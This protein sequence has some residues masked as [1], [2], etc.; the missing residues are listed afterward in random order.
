MAEIEKTVQLLQPSMPSKDAQGKPA[1]PLESIQVL[2]KIAHN[3]SNTLSPVAPCLYN[4]LSTEIPL[5]GSDVDHRDAPERSWRKRPI[6]RKKSGELIRPAVRPPSARRWAS[7]MPGTPTFSKAVHFDSHLE[8]VRLFL[9]V[10]RPW[11]VSAGSSPVEAYDSDTEFL[12]G[13]EDSSN[14]RSPPYEWEL[15]A[16]KFPAKTPQRLLLSVRV[17]KVFLS[18]DNEILIGSV[19]VA[20]LAFH[21]IVIA[22]YTLDHWTTTSEVVAEYNDGVRQQKN[23]DG[24]DRFNFNLKLAD[25]ANLDAKTMFFCVKYFVN[26]KEYWDNNDSANF[27]INF[28]KKYKPQNEIKSM[29][30]TGSRPVHLSLSRNHKYLSPISA[31][32]SSPDDFANGL[33]PRYKLVDP[34]ESTDFL[35]EPDHSIRLQGS[36]SVIHLAPH[37]LTRRVGPNGQAFGNRYDF[38]VSLSAATQAIETSLGDCSGI[39]MTSSSKSQNKIISDAPITESHVSASPVNANKEAFAANKSA[40][41]DAATSSANCVDSPQSARIERQFLASQSYNELLK[42][43]CFARSR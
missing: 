22:R 37:N 12:L 16:S 19:A 14:V 30:G 40:S 9:Q 35:A 38:S 43:Y 32:H 25:Q 31:G 5:V 15:D 23:A 26:G 28:R 2:R 3:R 11:A 36:Q 41:R 20:D 27:Q 7:S 17:E 8:D 42:S 21:K 34:K 4:N 10:D 29:Q 1:D 33:D 39:Y 13:K 24:Y 18:A 6:L